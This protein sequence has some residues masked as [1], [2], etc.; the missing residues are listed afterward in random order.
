MD[1]KQLLQ[2]VAKLRKA[3]TKLRRNRPLSELFPGHEFSVNDFES[4]VGVAA[5]LRMG[6]QQRLGRTVLASTEPAFHLGACL[7][8]IGR[9]N[10]LVVHF[11]D[12]DS[13]LAF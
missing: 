3:L 7:P 1:L 5:K 6:R 4:S 13:A 11:A 2:S 8:Q 10:A 12:H 9:L